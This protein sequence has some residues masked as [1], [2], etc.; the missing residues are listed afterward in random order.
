LNAKPE[1]QTKLKANGKRFIRYAEANPSKNVKNSDSYQSDFISFPSLYALR[2]FLQ[3]TFGKPVVDQT[4]ITNNLGLIVDWDM[5][6][7]PVPKGYSL[8][9]AIVAHN[10]T[11]RMALFDQLGLDLVPTNMPVEMLVVEKVK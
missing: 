7:I 8:R 9:Q 1:A 3:Y 10:E 2:T 6:R 4:G 5:N 11:L